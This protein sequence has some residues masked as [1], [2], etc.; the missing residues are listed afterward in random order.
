MSLTTSRR[1]SDNDSRFGPFVWSKDGFKKWGAVLDSGAD[2]NPGCHL[3][4]YFNARTLLLDLPTL[5]KPVRRWVD[6]SHYKWA[7]N[8]GYWEEHKKEYGLQLSDGFLQVFFG[9]QTDDSCTTKDWCYHLPWTQ[10]TFHRHS[11]YNEAGLHYWT[12]SQ[13]KDIGLD[14]YQELSVVRHECPS[15]VFQFRDFDGELVEAR[16][17]IEEREW[18][19]GTGAF[20]WLRWVWPSRVD[21]S[22]ELKF[23]SEVGPRKG[24]WKGGT[25]GHGIRMLPNEL[26]KGA[27]LRYCAE[28]NMTLEPTPRG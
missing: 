6:I 24:S 20:K 1:W 26:H 11:L 19:R 16:T 28:H 3:R 9:P 22:L 21:R 5:I 17:Q 15:V 4:F 18:H 27:F 2:E 23:S 10:W 25:V 13:A 8:P 12:Q 7:T 14:K